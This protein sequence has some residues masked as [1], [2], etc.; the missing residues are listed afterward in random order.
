MKPLI[1]VSPDD[2]YDPESHRP[3]YL[4]K[5]SY[6]TALAG[7]GAMPV[8]PVETRFFREYAEL[9]DGL[10]LT[11]GTEEINP[12][13]YGE[14]ARTT[15]GGKSWYAYP[16]SYTRD[17]VDIPLCRAF[18]EAKKPVM[19]IGRGMHVI[20]VVLGGKPYQDIAEALNKEH[21]EGVRHK[22]SVKSGSELEKLIGAEA[23][24]NSYHHQAIKD[25]GEGLEAAAYSSDGLIEA[26]WHRELPVFG[27]QWNPE[28]YKTDD[29]I[30]LERNKRPIEA[31]EVDPAKADL[32]RELHKTMQ[33]M[34]GCPTDADAARPSDNP[35]FNYFVALCGK[36]A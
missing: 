33:P 4:I 6:S 29:E 25:L 26:V 14:R 10:L 20:N 27:V 13:R 11:D 16:F 36:E 21:P 30:L 18:L 5:R 9:A 15:F 3:L 22:I 12:G 32:F 28:T 2:A 7:A 19:G 35:L 31:A 34:P 1:L 24:V 23:E 8:M 17:S